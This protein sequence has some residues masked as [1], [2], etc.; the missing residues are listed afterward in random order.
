MQVT[1]WY[2]KGINFDEA[3]SSLSE[4][5]ASGTRV[6]L[7]KEELLPTTKWEP[8]LQGKRHTEKPG[9]VP[10]E[11]LATFRRGIATGSNGFFLLSA[12]RLKELGI[13]LDRCFPCVGIEIDLKRLIYRAEDFEE[14]AAP[15]ARL[16][17]LNLSDPLTDEEQ[18]YVES[19]EEQSLTDR[20]LLKTRRPWYS[21]EQRKVAPIWSAVFGRGDLKFVFNEAGVRSLTNFHCIYP[22]SIDPTFHKALTLCLNTTGSR[23]SSKMHGRVYG[24]GLNKFEPHDLKSIQVPDLR[25]V[26]AEILAE[27]S[28]LLVDLDDAPESAV[29]HEKADVVCAA[30]AE[31]AA[32]N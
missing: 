17:L 6:D 1:G 20:F 11:E 21:M 9:W 7:R 4:L 27:L 10:L 12:D 25:H 13:G 23:E 30:A 14:A 8:L 15:G 24:G 22:H 19:G 16:F 28:D 26:P 18:K 31:L 29:L 3:P 32:S 2:L 5:V